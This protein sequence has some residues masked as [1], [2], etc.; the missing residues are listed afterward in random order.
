[1]LLLSHRGDHTAL[2]EN[3]LEAFESA[4]HLGV[5]GF[6]TDVRVCADGKVILFHDRVAPNGRLVSTLSHAHLVEVVGYP[7]PTL[8][9][10]LGTYADSF[11]NLELKSAAA[12]PPMLE[13]LA[14]VKP[15]GPILI[16]SFLHP[17]ILEC[18]E[19]CDY[20]CGI[21]IAHLPL[22]AFS[23]LRSPQDTS[24]IHTLVVD[25]ETLDARLAEETGRADLRLFVYGPTT[26]Q[27]HRLAME[28][29]VAGVI[30]DE[31]KVARSTLRSV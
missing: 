16:T 22:T 6:E 17:V 26:A 23:L 19:R 24:K 7:V 20:D 10:V 21:I 31:L 27:D 14:K 15:C 3:T 5:D 12:L 11:W 29:N 1:M 25:F 13:T 8:E 9:A 30:T 4:K 18:S 28:L 2:P